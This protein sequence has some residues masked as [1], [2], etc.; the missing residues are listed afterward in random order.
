M[1]ALLWLP[2]RAWYYDPVSG[3]AVTQNV[4]TLAG[5]AQL[6]DGATVGTFPTQL[7]P[8]SANVS[9]GMRFDGGDW[10]QHAG[11]GNVT[12]VALVACGKFTKSGGFPGIMGHVVAG[13]IGVALDMTGATGRVTFYSAG[14]TQFITGTRDVADGQVHSI[15]GTYRSS[16]GI[17][18]LYVD[19]VL[20]TSA[21]KT[22]STADGGVF[23]VG[24]G[25]VTNTP[26]TASLLYASVFGYALSGQQAAILHQSFMKD[27]SA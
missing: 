1:S 12:D 26:I 14:A 22:A 19:G 16:T 6:G 27:L 21:A 20:D 4:G 2:M 8:A 25:A 18:S 10:L 9:R 5:T 24:R 15:V 17:A 23:Y 13:T 11:V 7:S 3:L